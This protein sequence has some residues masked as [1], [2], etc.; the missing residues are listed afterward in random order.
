MLKLAA[1]EMIETLKEDLDNFTQE[2]LQQAVYFIQENG[3][4]EDS[5]FKLREKVM[6]Y[7]FYRD[8]MEALSDKID[9]YV[10]NLIMQE[11]NFYVNSGKYT[12][13]NEK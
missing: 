4:P 10:D 11:D 6:M 9:S 3:V 8:E 12:N 5:S 13:P 1:V 7:L 2:S